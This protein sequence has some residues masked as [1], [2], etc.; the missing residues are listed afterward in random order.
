M[1]LKIS[2]YV[3][4][5][6]LPIDTDLYDVSADIGIGT[7][8]RFEFEGDVS[9]LHSWIL[10]DVKI[11]SESDPGDIVYESDEFVSVPAYST[12]D[13]EFT[14]PWDA[15]PGTYELVVSTELVGDEYP[16]NDQKQR[17]VTVE[18]VVTTD[19]G[20]IAINYPLS[21]IPSGSCTVSATVENFGTVDQSRNE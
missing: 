11:Y 16:G 3:N 15:L 19:V 1:G 6:I 9:T 7:Q 17:M 8:V 2:E 13:V 12:I 20:V 21:E 5:H 10:D 14:P 4:A 18:S